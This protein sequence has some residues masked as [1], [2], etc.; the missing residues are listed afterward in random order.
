MK[1]GKFKTPA[2]HS[3]DNADIA[4]GNIRIKPW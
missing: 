3:G 1:Y 4:N 2:P